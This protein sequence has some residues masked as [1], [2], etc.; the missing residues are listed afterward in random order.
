MFKRHYFDMQGKCFSD[1][2]ATIAANRRY[3]SGIMLL[4]ICDTIWEFSKAKNSQFNLRLSHET[5]Q[6]MY[7]KI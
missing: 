6:K 7:D 3:D 5:R 2:L 4:K 1:T